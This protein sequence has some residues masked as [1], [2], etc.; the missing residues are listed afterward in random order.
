[1]QVRRTMTALMAGGVLAGTALASP[2]WAAPPSRN[3]PGPYAM[4]TSQELLDLAE[5]L[6]MPN[7]LA[8]RDALLAKVD[9]NRDGGLCARKFVNGSK[10]ERFG[11]ID[12][13]AR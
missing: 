8:A 5:E 3:C 1:M 12:N 4:H 9:K 13:N 7:P 11:F 10:P 6:G 2:S